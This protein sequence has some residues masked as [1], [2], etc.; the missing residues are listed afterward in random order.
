M[1]EK[2]GILE[3]SIDKI[4]AIKK[5]TLFLILV[6]I[7]G[8]IL[9]LTAAIN[10]SVSA[11][12]MHHVTHAIN[13][14]SADRLITYDQSSGL[15]HAFTSVIYN[16]IGTTQ[17]ASRMAAL[18]FG[19]LSILVIYL[20]TK[21]F[22]NE[23]IALFSSFL[24]AI[25]PFHILN[26]MPE[27]D[28][29]AM[30]F[31]LTAMFLFIRA[32][33]NNK[34]TNYTISGIFIGLA[35]YTKVYPLLFIP[36]FLLFFIYWNKKEKKKIISKENAKKILIFLCI[37]FI[38]TLPALTHNYLLYKYKGFM[39]LQFTRTLG[40]GKNISAQYYSWDHQ[41]DAKNDWKGLILGHSQHSAS[42]NPTIFVT[43]NFIRLD[44]P[45]N[46]YLGIIGI[47][48]ILIY[49]KEYR[50][51]LVF[52]LLSILF[53][54]PFLAS[55]IILPKHYLFFELLLVPTSALTLNIISS[56]ISRISNK[57]KFTPLIFLLV[58]SLILLGLPY[59]PNIYHPD[60][61]F[62][63]GK[64]H[65]AQIMEFKENNIPKNALI[66]ADSR[67]YRGRINWAFQGRPYLEA[68]DFINLLTQKDKLPGK[69]ISADIYFFECVKD[70]CGWGTIKDQPGLNS[71]M[72][73]I[74]DLFKVNGKLEASI[75]EP[76]EDK[77][78]YPIIGGEKEK[79]INVYSG[80]MTI[81]D[82]V[83][84]LASQSKS[85]F[86]YDIGYQPIEKQFDYYK[87]EGFIDITLDKIAHVVVWL[88][89][90]LAFLSPIFLILLL[91]SKNLE[92]FKS[93]IK[94]NPNS[95]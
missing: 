3:Q 34:T 32:L 88:A 56:Q 64:S 50:R 48:L 5:S 66:I 22:F 60:M 67:I 74:V 18:I 41:F 52:F 53:V 54:L 25:A 9:R 38:F 63:Y 68:S 58:L 37:I 71:S 19:S 62:F 51:Y 16:I 55:V 15:W 11:D 92:S 57:L 46:F 93:P 70:D 73:S 75:S 90:I 89:V 1:D 30:F 21:E 24:L 47:F 78:F 6:F 91:N 95:N 85:W 81:K 84:V 4:F 44:D 29:M 82:S 2:N 39:D 7:L 94:E 36:S 13:F 42:P 12:D 17:L 86:L 27:Q 14:L 65:M 79:V 83:L 33:K 40:L 45:I 59:I 31:V 8:F 10:L 20:L 43:T 49:R 23:K 77:T 61:H 72:E 28:V 76:L 35:V 69:D 26:T 80:K 87:P